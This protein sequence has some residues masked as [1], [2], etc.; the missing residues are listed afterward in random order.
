MTLVGG[1]VLQLEFKEAAHTP[2]VA[3]LINEASKPKHIL[4]IRER[5]EKPVKATAAA[6]PVQEGKDGKP[7][8]PAP[9]APVAEGKKPVSAPAVAVPSVRNLSESV[10]MARRLSAAQ[11]K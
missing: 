7:A 10:S 11:P 9:A 3:K 4:A 6:K 5:L 2:E 8:A 1:R